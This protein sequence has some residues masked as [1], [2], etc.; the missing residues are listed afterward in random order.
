M[1]NSCPHPWEVTRVRTGTVTGM[2]TMLAVGADML[3]DMAVEAAAVIG[4]KLVVKVVAV[5]NG[6]W[7]DAIISDAS[8]IGAEVN[9]SGLTAVM[10]VLECAFPV[11]LN[12]PF[13]CCRAPFNCCS[14][15]VLD[16]ARALQACKPSCHVW[17][18]RTSGSLLQFPNQEPPRPQ[19]LILPDFFMVP[20]FGHT[21]LMAVVFVAACGY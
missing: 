11:P 14:M 3:T 2:V 13:S 20:H 12:K 18:T 8:A 5:L 9:P 15:T 7:A 1:P 10:A 4:L 17:P 16:C 6:D 21:E 19:Q